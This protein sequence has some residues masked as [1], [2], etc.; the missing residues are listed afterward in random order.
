MLN[1]GFIREAASRQAFVRLHRAFEPVEHTFPG[2]RL[3]KLRRDCIEPAILFPRPQIR[4]ILRHSGCRLFWA[5]VV[6]AE[7]FQH[8]IFRPGA[9]YTGIDTLCLLW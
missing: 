4:D 6:K 3:A 2:D 8:I 1:G 9:G 7:F 5:Q